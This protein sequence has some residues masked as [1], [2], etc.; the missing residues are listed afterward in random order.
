MALVDNVSANHVYKANPRSGAQ[1][2]STRFNAEAWL[3]ESDWKKHTQW[4]LGSTRY[5]AERYLKD[6]GI[7]YRIVADDD[8]NYAITDDFVIERANLEIEKGIVK[9]VTWG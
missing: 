8:D 6:K 2:A 5:Y 7:D 1:T 3:K 9:E 4:L